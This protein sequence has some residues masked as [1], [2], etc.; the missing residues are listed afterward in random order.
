ME[1]SYRDLS[2]LTKLLKTL[3]IAGA[4]LSVISMLS[5]FLQLSLLQS[6]HV[7]T[8]AADANDLRERVIGLIEM[9]LFIFTTVFVSIW[10]VR[11]NRNVRSLGAKDMRITPGWAVGYFFIPIVNLWRPYQAMSDLWRA[12]QNPSDWIRS[13]VGSAVPAWWTLWIISG[14]VG[15]LA[16]QKSM[17]A[18][19]IAD[20][21]AATW[22]YIIN[23]TLHIIICFVTLAMVSQIATAQKTQLD[24]QSM[25]ISTVSV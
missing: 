25:P 13:N 16:M 21:E 20:L 5:S 24:Y 23:S 15:R 2:G 6:G 14:I 22:F 17:A 9:A 18:H 7:T 1:F 12:S 8:E 11:A 3:F 4:V 19:G 10:I